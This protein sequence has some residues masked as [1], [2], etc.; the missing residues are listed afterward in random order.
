MVSMTPTC[1]ELEQRYRS[2]FTIYLEN[3]NVSTQDIACCT[4]SRVDKIVYWKKGIV[5][6]MRAPHV[7][8]RNSNVALRK[9]GLMEVWKNI[10]AINFIFFNLLIISPTPFGTALLKP[11]SIVLFVLLAN[12]NLYPT[13]LYCLLCTFR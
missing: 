4:L 7:Y 12:M 13:V 6:F 2:F 9:I 10:F 11:I 5:G 8:M 1:R 3:C